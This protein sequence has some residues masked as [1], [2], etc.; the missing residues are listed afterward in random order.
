ME[1]TT[2][3]NFDDFDFSC[4]SLSNINFLTSKQN[5]TPKIDRK[6]VNQKLL[7]CFRTAFV[8]FK[9]VLSFFPFLT[10]WVL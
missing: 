2:M 3:E 5:R 9:Y 1:E 10:Y 4:F 6:I 8:I 7:F